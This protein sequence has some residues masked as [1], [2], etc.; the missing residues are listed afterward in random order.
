MNNTVKHNF[1]PAYGNG[2]SAE[3]RAVSLFLSFYSEFVDEP[4]TT[5]TMF[6][7]KVSHKL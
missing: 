7:L 3:F 1:T 4:V 2:F 6:G 5:L